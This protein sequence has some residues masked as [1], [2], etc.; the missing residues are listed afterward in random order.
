MGGFEENPQAG[1]KIC[2]EG[3]AEEGRAKSSAKQNR[4]EMLGMADAFGIFS[5]RSIS[6]SSG[7]KNHNR[8]EIRRNLKGRGRR[9]C[10]ERIDSAPRLTVGDMGVSGKAAPLVFEIWLRENLQ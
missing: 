3:G 2:G 1:V 8:A 5:R 10:G 7:V 4:E 6:K 9:P